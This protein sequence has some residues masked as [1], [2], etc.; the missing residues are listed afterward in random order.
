M[1][2]VDH[3]SA[4][5]VVPGGDLLG[6]HAHEL[7]YPTQRVAGPHGIPEE[8]LRLLAARIDGNAPGLGQGEQHAI[9]QGDSLVAGPK[10][11]LVDAEERCDGTPGLAIRDLVAVTV[12]LPCAGECLSGDRRWDN[13]VPSVAVGWSALP[14]IA[15]VELDQRVRVDSTDRR[16]HPYVHGGRDPD[17]GKGPPAVLHALVC[18]EGVSEPGDELLGLRR[19]VEVQEAGITPA[20]RPRDRAL[21]AVVGRQGQGPAPEHVPEVTQQPCRGPRG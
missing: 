19:E 12:D 16:Q 1:P 17:H 3:R 6:T 13:Q 7:A 4:G 8:A 15:P 10:G 2:G 21:A 11:R 9:D 20:H 5:D 14:E 18:L